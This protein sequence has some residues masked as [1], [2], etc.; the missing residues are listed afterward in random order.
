MIGKFLIFTAFVISLD[1]D[2]ETCFPSLQLDDQKF[3][4]FSYESVIQ[5]F[6]E[7]ELLGKGQTGEIRSI[8]IGGKYFAVKV[9]PI[10][11]EDYMLEEL[12]QELLLQKF[13]GKIDIA[14]KLFGC[15]EYDS[16]FFII[17]E[18]LYKDLQSFEIRQKMLDLESFDRLRIYKKLAENFQIIHD[19]RFSHQDIKLSNIMSLDE[20]LTEFRIID[21]EL[22]KMFDEPISGGTFEFEAPE[23]FSDN[24]LASA[25]HDIYAF[26][27]TIAYSEQLEGCELSK[28]TAD[29]YDVMPTDS[30]V[31]EQLENLEKFFKCSDIPKLFNI[32]KKAI[33]PKEK[34]YSSMKEM[35][36]DIDKLANEIFDEFSKKD[37]QIF[38]L[39]NSQLKNEK[40][41][42][43]FH[44]DDV[45]HQSLDSVSY[46]MDEELNVSK[47]HQDFQENFEA[48]PKIS[49]FYQIL[50]KSFVD[51]YEYLFL[52]KT[53]IVM[54]FL[55]R[56]FIR[57]E[58]NKESE[59]VSINTNPNAL[60]N[61]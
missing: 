39:E 38:L 61:T 5:N 10:P 30:C 41:D 51:D 15:F 16:K 40:D 2:F 45:R 48:N 49:K 19:F 33:S 59:L 54:T 42:L 13:F 26:A 4:F 34:S 8:F 29:C 36:D 43:D 55:D 23:K 52:P 57:N 47:S 17:L 27:M 3:Q 32:V 53:H 9:V 31:T 56:L 25:Y 11:S 6:G 20:N 37:S 44:L 46:E 7:G 35:A 21:F 14:P 22:S 28:I 18:R 24:T 60:G 50:D 12:E 58:R 1:R